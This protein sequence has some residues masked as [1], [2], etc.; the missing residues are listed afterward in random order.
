[1]ATLKQAADVII[2]KCMNVK[3]GEKVLI[4][5]DKNKIDIANAFFKD[6][7][8]IEIPVGKTHGEEPS[9]NIAKEMLNYDI[10]LLITSKSLSHTKARRDATKKGAGIASMPGITE[11]ILKRC[12]D[13]DYDE[14]KK[15][16]EKLRELLINSREIKITTELGTDLTVSV[17]EVHG[18]TGGLLHNKGDF[19][20][21]PTGEVDSG[22][23]KAE[24]MLIIDASFGGLGKLSSP[25]KLEIV[26]GYVVSIQG[27]DSS[28]LNKILNPF[29]KQAYKIA[30]FGIGT[31]PK[32]VVTGNVLEDEK[33][34][35]TVHLA[36]GND[37]TYGG[38]N[39]VPIHLDGVMNSPTIYIDGK[40]IIEK[41]KFL[42][43]KIYK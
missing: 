15:V 34:L 42:N 27:E 29:G 5:T 43:E 11:D 2:K 20:N 32:A 1:M 21:L 22:V 26:D 25:L 8:L 23:K 4:L 14:L 41:G 35:G 18:K 9:E 17:T 38:K 16:H 28:R 40:K 37:L 24:G 33:V 6:Y 7:K 36:L 19:G 39:N 10:I 13:I 12:I 30:E 31:N 3:E